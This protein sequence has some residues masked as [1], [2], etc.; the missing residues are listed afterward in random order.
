MLDWV[1]HS[2]YS[3][4]YAN[5]WS[6]E[7]QVAQDEAANAWFRKYLA[8]LNSSSEAVSTAPPSASAPQCILQVSTDRTV[9]SHT[10]GV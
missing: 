1:H 7:L 9:P 4:T 8:F 2:R 6:A 10:C 3:T 5:C